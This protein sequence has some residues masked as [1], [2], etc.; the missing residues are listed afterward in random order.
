MFTNQEN[1]ELIWNLLKEQTKMPLNAQFRS[2]FDEAIRNI[3]Q[4]KH[5]YSSMIEMNKHLI[6]TCMAEFEKLSSSFWTQ[7]GTQ[8]KMLYAS[9][10]KQKQNDL[11]KLQG[12][13]KPPT[14][15]FKDKTEQEYGNVNRL[16][17]Q[18]M[19]DRQKELESIARSFEGNRAQ[20]TKWLNV[21]KAPEIKID[22]NTSVEIDVIPAKK[23]TFN[24][25]ASNI[26]VKLNYTENGTAKTMT[27]NLS[28]NFRLFTQGKTKVKS[29]IIL[30]NVELFAN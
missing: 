20:A 23:V 19:A 17:D 12:G 9:N 10:L 5:Q 11:E 21:E 16:M 30:E 22:R 3:V 25:N 8:V 28:N 1:K 6:A 26:Y 14:I 4:N 18:T 27:C 24:L 2:F 15:D 13:I 7:P 29:N